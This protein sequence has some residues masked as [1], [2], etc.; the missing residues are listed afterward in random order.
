MCSSYTIYMHDKYWFK[1]QCPVGEIIGTVSG[2][3]ACMC[4]WSLQY[5]HKI[6]G[7]VCWI[8][9]AI[10]GIGYLVSGKNVPAAV[11]APLHHYDISCTDFL[12]IVAIWFQSLESKHHKLVQMFTTQ[13]PFFGPFGPHKEPPKG[14][15]SESGL[16]PPELVIRWPILTGFGP[17]YSIWVVT[18]GM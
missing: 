14:H 15:S 2:K 18:T 17:K 13:W 12:N 3:N 6:A 4:C 11:S 8:V 1:V 5:W 7:A 10:I 16:L 9:E